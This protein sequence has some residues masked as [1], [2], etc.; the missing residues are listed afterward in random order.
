MVYKISGFDLDSTLDHMQNNDTDTGNNKN[1][2]LSE[3]N[4]DNGRISPDSSQHIWKNW[5]Y[6]LNS[7]DQSVLG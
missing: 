7:F 6:C 5:L 3:L 4:S 1:N 2:E